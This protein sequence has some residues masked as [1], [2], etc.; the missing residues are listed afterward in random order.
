MDEVV[1]QFKCYIV[2]YIM[3]GILV[4]VLDEIGM[5][6]YCF[7]GV[8][9]NYYEDDLIYDVMYFVLCVYVFDCLQVIVCVDFG[10]M[11]GDGIIIDLY[12]NVK[13]IC[14]QGFDVCQDLLM[15]V[16]LMYF[17][18]LFNDDIVCIDKLVELYWGLLI[19]NVNGFIFNNVMC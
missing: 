12:N 9:M 14:V 10:K 2:D 8:Y 1:I 5:I 17:Q 7:I 4:I 18:V 15:M 3:D 13:V 11:N 16:D 6:K 19:M